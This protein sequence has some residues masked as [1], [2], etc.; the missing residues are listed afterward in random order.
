MN[1]VIRCPH[2]R[3]VFPTPETERQKEVLDYI[4]EFTG[5]RGY[6]PSYMQ[7]AR[8]LGLRNKTTI[9]KHI[10]ALRRQGFLASL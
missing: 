8:Y 2:C 9:W 1:L 6:Q 4:V 5:R 7:I 3:H 10:R